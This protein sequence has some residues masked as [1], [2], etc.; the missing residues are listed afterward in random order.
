MADSERLNIKTIKDV[1]VIVF[2][3][4]SILDT[5]QVDEIGEQ[6]YDLVDHQGC[7]KL[8]LDF[9]NVKFLSSSALGVLITTQKKAEAG[10][11]QMILCGLRDDLRKVFQITRLERL[12]TF[13]EDQAAALAEFGRTTAG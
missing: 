13:R 10:R 3:D 5:V 1:T 9:A 7:R 8:V 12:F 2:E 11:G 6:L 4:I